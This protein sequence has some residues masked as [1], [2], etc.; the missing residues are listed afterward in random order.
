MTHYD[1]Y[2]RKHDVKVGTCRC[3]ATDK[4][5][6]DVDCPGLT[7]P[8]YLDQPLT[9]ADRDAFGFKRDDSETE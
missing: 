9:E 8:G 1:F 6:K 5:R 7:C 4:A 3:R 2:C